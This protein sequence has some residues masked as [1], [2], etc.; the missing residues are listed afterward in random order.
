[1]SSVSRGKFLTFSLIN[2]IIWDILFSSLGYFFGAF[3][4]ANWKRIEDYEFEIMALILVSGIIIGLF[5]RFRSLN[6][7]AKKSEVISG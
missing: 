4:K 1:M 3:L 5:L 2:T 7:F 6:R